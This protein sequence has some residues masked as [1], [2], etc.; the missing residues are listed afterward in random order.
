MSSL[1]ISG[2][3]I[4]IFSCS[5]SLPG[6]FS[7]RYVI[8]SHIDMNYVRSSAYLISYSLL[9]IPLCLLSAYYL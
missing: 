9:E 2:L 5:S 4:A 6:M 7:E 8:Y 3:F 1:F